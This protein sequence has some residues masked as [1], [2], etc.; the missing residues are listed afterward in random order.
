MLRHRLLGTLSI[1]AATAVSPVF[2]DDWR[3][4]QVPGSPSS[5]ARP[6]TSSAVQLGQP[7]RSQP[8]ARPASSP[9]VGLSRPVPTKASPVQQVSLSAPRARSL[10]R[11]QNAD[12]GMILHPP[13]ALSPEYSFPGGP[14]P[15]GPVGPVMG[16]VVSPAPA[17]GGGWFEGWFSEGGL[18]DARPGTTI[19]LKGLTFGAGVYALY[20]YW[21]TNPAYSVV[22]AGTVTQI[23][24]QDFSY[25][26]D[27]TPLV[28]LGYSLDCGL[29]VRARAWKFD[30]STS[31]FLTND[32][33]V[34][35]NSAA[36]L[37]LQIS[38]VTAG[39]QLGFESD[40]KISVIDLEATQSFDLGMWSLQFS[41]GAR[42]AHMSQSYNSV[43]FPL[44]G[45]ADTISSGHQFR[46]AGPTVAVELKRNLGVWGL[47][48]Y[49]S[50]RGALLFG[51]GKQ[52][53]FQVI[54]GN[55]A[56]VAS[57]SRSD[58]MPVT[59]LEFGIDCSKQIGHCKIY[60]QAAVV[61]MV[62]YGAGNA[63]NNDL[64][65]ILVDPEVS[66][67]GTNLGLFGGKLVFGVDF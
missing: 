44:L 47:G 22:S 2:A 66:N 33:L 26:T 28:W 18:M 64:I 27:F 24:Q 42:Y 52:D 45:G 8:A 12:E 50:A 67:N 54:N 35:I 32:G 5:A 34:A 43:L 61:G 17:Q 39:D 41:G 6:G 56:T 51:T 38:S 40:L 36:P 63:A 59:E 10:V 3:P 19:C 16:P 60:M 20:P 31:D 37:G 23:R 9:S 1:L 15:S 4:V 57:N 53:A 48:L 21:E 65:P 46:G 14:V 7:I 29:G 25:H 30:Q 62:W 11:G 55:P 58:V 49:G 13:T